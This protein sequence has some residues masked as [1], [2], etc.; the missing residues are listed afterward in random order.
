VSVLVCAYNAADTLEECLTSL[1]ALTYSDY[2]VIVVNDGSR[3]ATGEI[4]QRHPFCRVIDRDHAG[5]SAAR[6]AALAAATGDIVAYTDADVRVDPDWL[7][8]LVQPFATAGVVAAGGLSLPPL[9]SPWMAH[10]VARAP[11]GP[12]HVL[13]DDR[14]AEHVPGCNLA[15][16]RDALRAIGGFNPIYLRAG[17][18]V[19]VCWRLQNA[20]GRI[21][22]VPAA[23]VWH[24]HRASVR[25]FWRQQVGYGE[26]QSWLVP[27]HR[28]RFTG[29]KIAWRGHVYSPLPFVRSLSRPRVNL[30]IWGSA[31]FPSVYHMQSFAL[32][33]LPHSVRW[34]IASA[35]L[36]AAALPLGFVAG[37]AYA[38]PVAAVG[39][40]GMA[41]TIFLCVRY[42]LASDID[43]LPAIGGRSPRASRVIYR[44]MIAWLHVVQPFARATGNVRGMLHPPHVSQPSTARTLRPSLGDLAWALYLLGGGTFAPRFWAERWI[45]ADSLLTLMTDRLRATPLTRSVEIEDRWPPARDIRVPVWPFAWLDLLVLVENHAAGRSLI[46]IRHRLRPAVLTAL[47]AVAI[48]A[49]PLALLQAATVAASTIAAVISLGG[50]TMV[51]AAAWCSARTL[52]VA[53]RM[54]AQLAQEVDIQPIG[55]REGRPKRPFS[56]RLSSDVLVTPSQP[57]QDAE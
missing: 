14:T 49:L 6:N 52:S 54:M 16:R 45:G 57:C 15:V 11:G 33:F 43:T 8:F 34:Q 18:D 39:L 40:A 55:T 12:T 47:A 46:R 50:L 10:C 37:P 2:E 1:E 23:L 36:V 28:E 32:V 4:A 13:L 3:D 29:A 53:R 20:G 48:L 56:R 7:T 42:A 19:D 9:D 51:G 30:G 44:L 21:E 17:D 24:H 31:A 41:I 22:F 38:L 35:A 27:H 26:G 25:A 5:L